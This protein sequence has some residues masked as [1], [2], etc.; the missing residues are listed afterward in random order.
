[1][2]YKEVKVFQDEIGEL[3][4][5]VRVL[6]ATISKT[7]CPSSSYVTVGP[8]QLGQ[9]GQP[10]ES[11]EPQLIDISLSIRKELENIEKDSP[12][13]DD[14]SSVT[15]VEIKDILSNMDSDLDKDADADVDA[16]DADAVEVRDRT[17]ED[18]KVIST[19][20]KAGKADKPGKDKT[21]KNVKAIKAVKEVKEGKVVATKPQQSNVVEVV[22]PSIVATT[23]ASE[24]VSAYISPHP[25]LSTSDNGSISDNV[26]ETDFLSTPYQELQNVK[27]DILR[28]FLRK[29]GHHVKGNK[30]DLIKMINDMREKA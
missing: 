11:G 7:A 12:D 26:D 5:T 21:V 23:L 13:D 6:Q 18:V 25:S 16:A 28:N 2:L 1:M 4:S 19:N 20:G 29:L 15:S 8:G 9:L 3:K 27:Y 24:S 10:G 30:A 17:I 14:A 22:P